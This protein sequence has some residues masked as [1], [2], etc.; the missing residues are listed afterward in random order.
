VIVW[1]WG[2]GVLA[3]LATAALATGSTSDVVSAARAGSTERVS[4]DSQGGQA[5]EFP[6]EGGLSPGSFD[7]ALASSGR[8]VVF[9]SNAAD[10]VT[11]DAN[12]TGDVFLRDL[13]SGRTSRVSLADDE[14]EANGVSLNPD[15][16]AS[17]RFV[18][19]SSEASN[20]VAGDSNA[21]QDALVRR[22]APGNH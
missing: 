11:D 10:L 13:R 6:V 16:D 12:R 15:V 7:T 18:A 8:A 20:L 19:F 5:D 21:G 2:V 9:Y 17:G 4:V 3:A 14:Q 1:R 22:P